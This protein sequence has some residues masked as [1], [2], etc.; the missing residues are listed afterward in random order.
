MKNQ[1]RLMMEEYNNQM[2]IEEMQEKEKRLQEFKKQKEEIQI[3]KSKIAEGVAIGRIEVLIWRKK[4]EL[5]S[6]M[7]EVV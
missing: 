6:M 1:R 4:K 5:E 7:E 3:Q 2:K